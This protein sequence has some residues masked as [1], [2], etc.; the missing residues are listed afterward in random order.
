M[1]NMKKMVCIRNDCNLGASMLAGCGSSS[2]GSSDEKSGSS[3][4]K[5]ELTFGIWD[6][7]QRPAMEK[8]IEAYEKENENVTV[9]IQL[10]PYK[11]GEYWTK[12]EA[13]AGGGTAPDVFW[14]NVLHL[15]AYQEGGILDDLSSAIADSDINDNFSETLVN[16][17]VREG[18]KLCSTERLRYQ[19]SV[20]QQRPVR[21]GRC[22]ISY[23]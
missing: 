3:K 7:N 4:G 16:N 20:V 5:T 8:L 22:G 17:Y 13:A 23:R 9:K 2:D 18:K 12:L 10:T 11:G 14:L 6:E 1:K 21:P 19:R 15:D